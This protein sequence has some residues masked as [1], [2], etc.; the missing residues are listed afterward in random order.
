MTTKLKIQR[1]IQSIEP[2]I[3]TLLLADTLSATCFVLFYMGEML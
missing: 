1:V 3:I 2:Q